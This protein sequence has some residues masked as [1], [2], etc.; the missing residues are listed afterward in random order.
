MEP[1]KILNSRRNFE[2]EKQSWRYHAPKFESMLQ[3]YNNQNGMVLAQ[4]QSN[5]WIEFSRES[6]SKLKTNMVS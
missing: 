1:Q 5:T 4:K 3:V 6:R 2:K